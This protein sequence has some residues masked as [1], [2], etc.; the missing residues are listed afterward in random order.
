MCDVTPGV[1]QKVCSSKFSIGVDWNVTCF[2]T[3][4]TLR[5][6]EIP[7]CL[8]TDP[9][10]QHRPF[11]QCW[12]ELCATFLDTEQ[13][14]QLPPGAEGIIIDEGNSRAS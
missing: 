3:A 5:T 1:P 11:Q 10:F 7:S 14:S 2:Q 8:D 13:N 6:R 12:F 4:A 9:E